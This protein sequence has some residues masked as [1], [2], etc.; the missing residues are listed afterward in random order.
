MHTHTHTH[1]YINKHTL[2]NLRSHFALDVRVPL[3]HLESLLHALLAELEVLDDV[4]VD[5]GGLCLIGGL[6]MAV[7]VHSVHRVL[8]L[9]LDVVAQV[10]GNTH[11]LR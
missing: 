1:V 9:C 10:L 8:L 11:H 3:K 5:A 6:D 7:V 2:T 4:W